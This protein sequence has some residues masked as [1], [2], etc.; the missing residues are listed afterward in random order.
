MKRNH[1]DRKQVY[2]SKVLS[3]ES[4][5]FVYTVEHLVTS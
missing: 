5:V 2:K 1:A 4:P 3:L